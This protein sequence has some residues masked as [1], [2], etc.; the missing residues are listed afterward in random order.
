MG[1]F[2]DLK[3]RIRLETQKARRAKSIL[4]PPAAAPAGRLRMAGR[5]VGNPVAQGALDVGLQTLEGRDP[6]DA[7]IDVAAGIAASAAASKALPKNPWI[8]IPGS[9]GAY[10]AGS[11]T[12]NWI[13]QN[14]IKP[15][16]AGEETEKTP[17]FDPRYTSTGAPR[18]GVG[19]GNAGASQQ[20]LTAPATRRPVEERRPPVS[21][22]V[23][24]SPTPEPQSM[25]ELAQLYA[26]Q[27]VLG[28]QMAEGGELQRRLYEG[29]AVPGMSPESLMSWVE[30]NPDLA[31][32]LAEKRGLL[33]TAV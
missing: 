14:L 33:P 30:A 19:G 1:W 3:N 5:I 21:R 2:E 31:Y 16:F 22:E 9:L 18:V 10:M 12:A 32:R 6:K 8:N 20:P 27:R 28:K 23:P 26:R 7:A 29:G 4:N 13:N 24:V 11:G 15:A 25:N 17:V